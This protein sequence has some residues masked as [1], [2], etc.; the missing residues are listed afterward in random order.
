MTNI[1]TSFR[2]HRHRNDVP[3]QFSL[4]V[5]SDIRSQDARTAV[6]R[7]GLDVVSRVAEWLVRNLPC[8]HRVEND[9]CGIPEHRFCGLCFTPM[10]NEPIERR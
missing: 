2:N 10:P 8:E 9:Q 1:V 7:E 4:M 5:V 3:W 6:G